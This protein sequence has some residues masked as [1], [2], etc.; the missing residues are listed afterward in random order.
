M[1]NEALTGNARMYF[2]ALTWKSFWRPPERRMKV[3]AIALLCVFAFQ[4]AAAL[5]EMSSTGDE[6]H[7]LGMGRYLLRTHRWDLAD[8]LLHPPLPYY[9]QSAL[10]YFA[11]VDFRAFDIADINARGRALMAASPDDRLLHLARWPVLLLAVLLGVLVAVWGWQS[12]GPAAGLSALFL[13][14]FSPAILSNAALI[15]PDLCLTFFSTLTFYFLWRYLKRQTLS[16]ILLVGSALG[17]TLL[18]KYAAILV[19]LAIILIAAVHK[20]G[21]R[22]SGKSDAGKIPLR[23]LAALFLVTILVVNAGYFFTGAFRFLD[24]LNFKSHLFQ[25]VACTGVLRWLPSPMPQAYVAGMD[26]QYTVV[27]NGFR[28]FLL[29]KVRPRGVF[30]YYVV[31]FLSKTPVPLLLLIVIALIFHRKFGTEMLLMI[32]LLA[33]AAIFL[34]YFSLTRVSRGIRYILPVYPLLFIW[35]GQAGMSLAAHARRWKYVMAVLALWYGVGCLSVAPHYLAYFNELCGGPKNGVNILDES[36]FDWGQELKSLGNYL[37]EHEIQ[38]VQLSYFGTADPLHYGI[39]YDSL[40]CD[41]ALALKNKEPIAV[42]ATALHW[43]CN[44]WLKGLKP[45]D[46]IGYTILLFNLPEDRSPR[47]LPAPH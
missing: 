44:W 1:Q 23:H 31:A 33:P 3:L 7:Y 32:V 13:Y 45:A 19:V 22:L 25:Q 5:R 28:C 17:L 43:D 47:N 27:E 14:A 16:M 38:R 6:T 4:G 2:G 46:R 30:L 9:L 20:I 10:L 29:G 15:T 39:S 24:G 36:D 40:P 35:A 8:A 41:S 37:R 18:S 21:K 11:P 42:S 12:C 26:L 34:S